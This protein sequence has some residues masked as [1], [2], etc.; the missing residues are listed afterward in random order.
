MWWD[1]IMGKEGVDCEIKDCYYETV[2]LIFFSLF[3]ELI[4]IQQQSN[5]IVHMW[6]Y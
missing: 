5:N 2:V 3:Q 6:R 1:W 4:V